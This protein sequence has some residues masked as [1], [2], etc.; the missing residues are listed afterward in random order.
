[1]KRLQR[2]VSLCLINLTKKLCVSGIIIKHGL[3]ILRFLHVFFY[4]LCLADERC[5]R[6]YLFVVEG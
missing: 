3:N 5:L 2:F 6:I 4:F 1:M